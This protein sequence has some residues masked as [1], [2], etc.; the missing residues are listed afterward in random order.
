MTLKYFLLPLVVFFFSPAAQADRWEF[1]CQSLD[2]KISFNR[3]YLSVLEAG[4]PAQKLLTYR[5]VD[6]NNDPAFAEERSPLLFGEAAKPAVKLVNLKPGKE[7]AVKLRLNAA[8][9]FCARNASAY[10][11]TFR[12]VRKSQASYVAFHCEEAWMSD[13]V[14]AERCHWEPNA[15]K[16][17]LR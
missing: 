5:N 14:D 16:E 4:H 9:K 11:T 1:G 8:N 17:I 2:G 13:R 3:R 15:G 12:V 7:V 10:L 6:V